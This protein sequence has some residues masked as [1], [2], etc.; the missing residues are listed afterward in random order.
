MPAPKD[1]K[2]PAEPICFECGLQHPT[3]HRFTAGPIDDQNLEESLAIARNSDYS[4]DREFTSPNEP[5]RSNSSCQN[6]A[7]TENG[8][9]ARN[10]LNFWS[11]GIF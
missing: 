4:N 11:D 8:A 9:V 1:S 2:Q 5:S 10:I 7:A 3:V 6:V